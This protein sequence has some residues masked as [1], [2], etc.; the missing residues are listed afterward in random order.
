MRQISPTDST[1]RRSTITGSPAAPSSTSTRRG[2]LIVRSRSLF[3]PQSAIESRFIVDQRVAAFRKAGPWLDLDDVIQ[4]GALEPER[5]LLDGAPQ[6]A[7]S[8]GPRGGARVAGEELQLDG[9]RGGGGGLDDE[10][11]DG[12]RG[13]R[14]RPARLERRGGGGAVP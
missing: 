4:H 9:A 8:G 6:G 10:P 3:I 2:V 13:R 11:L 5:D 1:A 14:P 12:G 7:P